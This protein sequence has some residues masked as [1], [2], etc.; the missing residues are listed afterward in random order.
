MA[1]K[2]HAA[3][4]EAGKA[5]P[6]DARLKQWLAEHPADTETRRYYADKTAQ[7]GKLALAIEQYGLVLDRN[8]NDAVVLNNVAWTMNK[9]KDPSAVRYAERAY[10]L[11]PNDGAVADTLG[12]ILVESGDLNRGI[13]I[14]NKGVADAPSHR[15]L[16]FH[17][18]QALAKSGDKPKA[19]EQLVIL[20]GSG[21]KFP[22]EA[23]A[24][25]MLHKLR[26]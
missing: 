25:S 19:I 15:E 7:R 4:M 10:A 14:L 5:D 21:G 8:P 12:Q 26:Q 3:C 6:C 22:Q 16:R 18:A 13:E 17:F 9:L 20:L 2:L 1:V 24:I 11:K 23:E